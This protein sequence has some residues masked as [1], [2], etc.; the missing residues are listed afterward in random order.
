MPTLGDERWIS[1]LWLR[2][3][4]AMLP[5]PAT[6]SANVFAGK[7]RGRPSGDSLQGTAVGSHPTRGG[8]ATP[9]T[10][11]A[12]ELGLPIAVIGSTVSCPSR[13]PRHGAPIG[14]RGRRSSNPAPSLAGRK[15]MESSASLVRARGLVPSRSRKFRVEGLSSLFQIHVARSPRRLD[16]ARSSRP[17]PPDSR[18]RPAEGSAS[19][20]IEP[21]GSASTCMVQR[22]EA[23]VWQ[24]TD[25]GSPT[26]WR[27]TQRTNSRNAG[28]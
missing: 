8:E 3:L 10:N 15:I 25:P 19:A 24:S 22:Q 17:R 4:R 23:P 27:L 7:L 5:F 2:R 14:A 18:S 21:G 9:G 26:L 13:H 28:T 1:F 16:L 11:R 20:G 6:F 12:G